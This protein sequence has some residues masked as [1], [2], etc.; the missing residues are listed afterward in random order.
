MDFVWIA[1]R[2][3]S[4]WALALLLGM[5]AS[6]RADKVEIRGKVVDA[7]TGKPITRFVEQG[8]S[9]RG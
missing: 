9:V 2:N 7:A 4:L 8:G 5:S 3:A 1:T 6:V